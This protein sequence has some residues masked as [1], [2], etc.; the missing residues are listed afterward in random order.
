MVL[1]PIP[2]LSRIHQIGLCLNWLTY[3]ISKKSSAFN[4][5]SRLITIT[6]MP[7]SVQLAS[8]NNW[9]LHGNSHCKLINW[10][11]PSSFGS[12]IIHSNCSIPGTAS[13]TLLRIRLL[14]SERSATRLVLDPKAT[15]KFSAVR[16]HRQRWNDKV[17]FMVLW[18]LSNRD[19]KIWN[20]VIT[21]SSEW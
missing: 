6:N 13:E 5:F 1:D 8:N 15:V 12:S 10:E 2:P 16:C 17:S 9:R 19:I 4:L 14:E 21:I 20:R 3:S 7:I 11:Y 18:N